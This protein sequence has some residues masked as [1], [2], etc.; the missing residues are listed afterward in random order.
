METKSFEQVWRELSEILNKKA[1]FTLERKV[2]NVILKVTE[3]KITRWS[4]RAQS[5][6]QSDISKREFRQVWEELMDQGEASTSGDPHRI[7]YA[8]MAELPYVE[9]VPQQKVIRLKDV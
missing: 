5:G 9:Y 2:R 7:V 3:D 8:I 1:V 6:E 4:E